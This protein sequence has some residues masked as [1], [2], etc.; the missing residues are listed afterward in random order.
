MVGLSYELPL[1]RALSSRAPVVLLYHGVARNSNDTGVDEAGFERHILFLKQHCDF[2]TPEN[3]GKS[4]KGSDKIRVL[5]TL[6]DGMRN[7]ATVVAPILRRYKVPALFFVCSRHAIAGNYLWFTYLSALEKH[8]PWNGFRFSGEFMDMSPPRRHANVGRLSE[9]L[10]GLTPHPVAMYQVI[11]EE[12][13]R[14]EDF[15][16]DAVI[17]DSYAGMVA[18][19]VGELAADP[20]FTVGI[21]TVDHP[22]LTKCNTQD[23]MQQLRDNKAWI[24]S[25]CGRSCD[26][27]AY[28]GGD[29]NEDVVEQS[30]HL[31]LAYGYAVIP[32]THGDSH[33]AIPRV[34]I[35]APSLLLLSLKV[36]WGNYIRRFRVKVG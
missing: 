2:V 24:E 4:R 5:L 10:L 13:P 25:T 27:I 31:G 7:N 19:Q 18:E 23:L 22:F 17:A 14:L 35:Y 36:F 20:L 29:Y 9:F 15:I 1:L 16:S 33:F 32:K 6:D 34:G 12:L 30:R 26:L 28:P 11:A 8:F 3:I 21:H